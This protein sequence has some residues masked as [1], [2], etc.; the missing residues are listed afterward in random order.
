MLGAA[1]KGMDSCPMEEFSALRVG[2]LLQLPHGSVI[3]LVIALGYRAE[4][5]G[6]EERWRRPMR[7][8]IHPH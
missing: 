1:A 5:A 6:V 8:I 4:D 7:D 2:G 3:P